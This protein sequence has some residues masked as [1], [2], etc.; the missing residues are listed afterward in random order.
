[1]C[2][3]FR[4]DHTNKWYMHNPAPVLE[5]KIHKLLLDFD[6]QTD[7]LISAR[8]PCLIIINKKK[9]ICKIVDF[10]VPANHWIKLKE[11]EKDKYHDLAKE[12]KKKLWNMNVTIMPTVTG[13]FCTVSKGLL[14]GTR[15]LGNWRLSGYHPNDSIIEN[16]Q[17][18]ENIPGD[19]RKGP[20]Y[21]TFSSGL[22]MNLN[23]RIK[24]Q[25]NQLPCIKHYIPVATLTDYVPKKKEEEDLP[26]ST[27]ALTHRYN[28]SWQHRK[29]RT[30]TNYSHQKRYVQDDKW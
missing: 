21:L 2:K 7:H 3:K 18:T 26:A 13:A 24:E 22:E 12:L 5:N 30:T 4:F 15:G 10:A 1:M 23:K 27:T 17:N 6:V 9:R 19:L 11:Q 28:G 8:I 16:G 20:E 14:K 25:E 29:T